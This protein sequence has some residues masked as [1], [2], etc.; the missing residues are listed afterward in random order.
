MFDIDPAGMKSAMP[1]YSVFCFHDESCSL[2]KM[3]KSVCAEFVLKSVARYA[4]VLVRLD[5]FFA[6]FLHFRFLCAAVHGVHKGC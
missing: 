4:S 6:Y 3:T 5:L 2:G 1:P